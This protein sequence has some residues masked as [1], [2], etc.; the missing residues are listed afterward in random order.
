MPQLDSLIN[1]NHAFMSYKD[2]LFSENNTLLSNTKN[3]KMLE[4]LFSCLNIIMNK[5]RIKTKDE[6]PS[7]YIDENILEQIILI[8]AEKKNNKYYLNNIEFSTKEE[9][10]KIIR[11]KIA[12]GE[13]IIDE[14]SDNIIFKIEDQDIKISSNQLYSL[15]I[16]LV[17]RLE[18]YTVSKDYSRSQVFASLPNISKIKRE[19]QI[20]QI[21][22][23]IYHIEYNFNGQDSITPEQK[24]LIEEILRNVPSLISRLEEITKKPVTEEMIRTLFAQ[25]NLEVTPKITKLSETSYREKLEYFILKNIKQLKKMD[26]KHQVVLISN[27]YQKLLNDNKPLENLTNGVHYN[28]YTL[29]N[30]PNTNYKDIYEAISNLNSNNLFSSIVEMIVTTELLGFYIHFQ[31]PLENICKSKDNTEDGIDYFD[32]STLDLSMLTPTIF[33]LPEGRQSSYSDAINATKRRLG[34][35]S[36]ELNTLEL[37]ITNLNRLVNTSTTE[38]EKT[39]YQT[40]IYTVSE[41]LNKALNRQQEEQ[42]LLVERQKELD[43]FNL[44]D[45]TNYYHNRYLIE[46]IRNA[47]SHGNVYF[48][49]NETDGNITE[50]KLRF[51]NTKDSQVTLDLLVSIQDFEKIFNQDNLRLLD[52]YLT[53]QK[54]GRVL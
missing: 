30:L 27:W 29:S 9:I 42:E 12:H 33:N 18:L 32:Y 40:A 11:N 37:Q 54:K 41:K 43:E 6:D 38:E 22:E 17:E 44:S 45:Q 15:S 28:L 23:N 24:A 14:T 31:Y 53:N 25:H 19:K 8:I 52:E 35:I 50:C 47:I 4:V 7:N 48:Y 3:I 39:R 13:F 34:I 16:L 2:F 10:I 1:F 36:T 5:D 49:Y 21:L 46:Y 26:A 20:S 51:I